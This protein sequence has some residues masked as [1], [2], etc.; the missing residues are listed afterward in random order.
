MVLPPAI[1]NPP[2]TDPM[3]MSA[4]KMMIMRGS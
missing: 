1:M 2:T 4:P 3:T